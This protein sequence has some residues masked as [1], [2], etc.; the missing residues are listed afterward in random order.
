ML[1]PDTILYVVSKE[2]RVIGASQQL[3]IK[4]LERCVLTRDAF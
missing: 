1:H 3:D 4:A 2:K